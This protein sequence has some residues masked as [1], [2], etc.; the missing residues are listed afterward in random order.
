METPVNTAHGAWHSPSKQT[1]K[2]E[3]NEKNGYKIFTKNQHIKCQDW[4][5]DS[6][7][8]TPSS[9]QRSHRDDIRVTKPRVKPWFTTQDTQ[10]F[11]TAD[12]VWRKHNPVYSVNSLFSQQK[13]S[14]TGSLHFTYLQQMKWINRDTPFKT[15]RNCFTTMHKNKHISSTCLVSCPFLPACLP[16]S[17]W[18]KISWINCLVVLLFF[19]VCFFFCVCVCVC[20][21][22]CYF[23]YF[24][25][26]VAWKRALPRKFARFVLFRLSRKRS[27]NLLCVLNISNTSE[28]LA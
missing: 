24:F 8:L 4:L 26:Y 9:Q 18:H 14:I 25:M 22:V 5:I 28:D 20:V 3:K 13:P 17:N 12:T 19:F 16:A 1:K 6:W 11:L 27:S 10:Y 2:T 21:C 23:F 7:Y 15:V